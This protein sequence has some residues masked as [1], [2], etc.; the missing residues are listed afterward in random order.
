M[1]AENILVK[2]ETVNLSK[3]EYR[4][5]IYSQVSDYAQKYERK[6]LITPTDFFEV[7]EKAT[8]KLIEKQNIPN[9]VLYFIVQ[10]VIIKVLSR[11]VRDL[12]YMLCH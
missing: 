8:E 12:D 7:C 5:L 10:Q 11:N 2:T 3:E 1:E 4:R 9:A 6:R